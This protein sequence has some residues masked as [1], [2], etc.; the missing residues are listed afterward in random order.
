[1]LD[2]PLKP[3]ITKPIIR[4]ILNDGHLEFSA[5][6]LEEM[7]KDDLS[8]PDII[9]VLRGGWPSPGEYERGSWRY[10]ISTEAITAVVAFRSPS[11]LVVV[12]AWREQEM[13]R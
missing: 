7:K 13:I 12:T 4:A 5:H 6:A 9:N 3:S 11:W 1:M 10:R 8:E 2:E